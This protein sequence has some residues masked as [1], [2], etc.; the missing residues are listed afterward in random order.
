[1]STNKEAVTLAVISSLFVIVILYFMPHLQQTNGALSCGSFEKG[2]YSGYELTTCCDTQTDKEGIEITWCTVCTIDEAGEVYDC[3]PRFQKEQ[4]FQPPLP[5]PGHLNGGII[6][7]PS[8]TTNSTT[9][10]PGGLLNGR[11]PTNTFN[12]PIA[13]TNGNTSNPSSNNTSG[14]LN[15]IRGASSATR[16][17]INGNSPAASGRQPPQPP[18]S[19]PIN[20]SSAAMKA[21]RSLYS[22]TGGCI[23][24][25]STCVPCDIG[26]A[27]I[28]AN[29][30]PSGDWHPT[31]GLPPSLTLQQQQQ[32]QPTTPPSTTT[33]PPSAGLLNKAP[34]DHT[35]RCFAIVKGGGP[36]CNP[37]RTTTTTNQQTTP[38]T[39][40]TP[41]QH[42][43]H[44]GSNNNL[45]G[46]QESTPIPTTKKSKA[47]K[48]G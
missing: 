7:S 18:Y 15:T 19:T 34:T 16:S 39:T 3:G 21:A 22:P 40:T 6:F 20:S 48:T 13:T 9:Q 47:P 5:P 46:G 11:I 2:K 25:G 10:P 17:L 14:S 23:P 36:V 28:G 12:A 26:L 8:N 42:H 30:I 29:C 38:S 4:G 27:R 41:S 32:Q 1:M 31:N 33:L 45:Q 44:K 37:S 24:G 35:E 43:H